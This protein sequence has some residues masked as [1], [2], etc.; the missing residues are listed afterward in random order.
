MQNKQVIAALTGS[1]ATGKSV[2]LDYFHKNLGFEIISA[3]SVGHDVLRLE[4]TIKKIRQ[5]FGDAV[6]TGGQ[7]DRKALGKIV[8]SDESEL[9]KLNA[10]THPLILKQIFETID[11]MPKSTPVI[12][13]AAILIEAGWQRY[14]DTIMVTTC[15]PEIQLSRLM[16]R[17]GIDENEAKK[18]ISCQFS[19]ENR[20]PYAT[21][22]IDTSYGIEVTKITLEKIAYELLNKR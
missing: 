11:K 19:F 7:I 5:E 15:R 4:K 8:F 16:T 17:D 14:F 1:I 13:E 20:L 6:I 10:V 22:I 12:V 21:Y 9:K 2:V 18:R 3:D